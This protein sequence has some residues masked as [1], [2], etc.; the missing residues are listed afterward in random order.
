MARILYAWE[1][2]WQLSHLANIEMLARPLEAAG[3]E[4]GVAARELQDAQRFFAGMRVQYYQAP[5]KQGPGPELPGYLCYAHLLHSTGYADPRELAVLISAWSGVLRSFAPDLVIFDH[6][7]T[8]L[9]ASRALDLKR[10]LVGSGFLVP[11]RSNGEPLGVFPDLPRSPDRMAALR[12]DEETV[13]GVV[14][15]A[16]EPFGIAPLD[17]L[18]R[19][20]EDAEERILLTFPELDPFTRGEEAEYS[21]VW[22]RGGGIEPPWRDEGR[23]RIFGYLSPF[24]GCEALLEALAKCDAEV[25]L[26]APGLASSLHRRFGA[27]LHFLDELVDL[28]ALA[29][30]CDLFVSHAA[31][32]ST[33]T[34][35]LG[36]IPQLMIPLY[37]EQAFTAARVQGLG[38]G[39]AV[40]AR[41]ASWEAELEAALADEGLRKGARGFADRHAGFD[42]GVAAE[43]A[44][45]R[46]LALCGTVP[47]PAGASPGRS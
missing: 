3:H 29:G 19:L 46:L 12:R 32:S 34:T 17:R 41:G 16:A 40:E 33:A 13:L 35:L 47:G 15:R 37:R 20:Y 4:I 23:Q 22:T 36:G 21:G 25:M 14:N 39:R 1:L 26:F 9:L 45:E 31:H 10:V 43:R 24:E 11:P 38:A 30:A 44:R 18:G 42:P 27:N 6:S 7:P 5:F 2:G 8:A 28:L